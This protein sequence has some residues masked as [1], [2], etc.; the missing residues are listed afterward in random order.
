MYTHA[1][2]C[3]RTHTRGGAQGEEGR[4][5]ERE[6]SSF[7]LKMPRQEQSLQPSRELGDFPHHVC[8]VNVD[9]M[10]GDSAGADPSRRSS[11]LPVNCVGVKRGGEKA[12]GED[13][14]LAGTEEATLFPKA[15]SH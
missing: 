9:L 11:A 5:K 7:E 8:W 14:S 3:A 10:R 4:E 6:H 13:S 2:A 1:C 15:P 12:V